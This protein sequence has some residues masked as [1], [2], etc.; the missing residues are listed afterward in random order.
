M[1]ILMVGD[2]CGR[3]GRQMLRE[4]VPQL[5]RAHKIDLTIVNGENA[6]AGFGVTRP[7]YEEILAAGADVVTLGNHTFDKRE[8]VSLLDE[9]PRL[10]RP[11]NYPPGTP[12]QGYCIVQAGGQ[13]VLV[14]NAMGRVFLPM[15]LDCPFRGVD[16]LLEEQSGR[17]DLFF[18]DFHAEATSEKEAMGWYLDGRAAGVVGTHTHIQTADDRVLPGGTA[19]LTDVG[20]TGPSE[21]VL[22][23]DR[24]AVI[25]RFLSQMPARFEVAEGKRQ[26]SAVVV[27]TD[28][29]SGLATEV[30]RILIRE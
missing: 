7:I 14:A 17:Y 27:A 9:E 16:A 20:M 15:D 6:A 12:G 23:M 22:G 24:K 4:Q 21:S 2:V 13:R 8:A 18:L 5:K 3:P 19:Y 28:P 26:I 1:R 25:G 29:E 11:L 10:L 30:Q